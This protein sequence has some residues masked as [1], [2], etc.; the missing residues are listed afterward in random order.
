MTT[1][2]DTVSDPLSCRL[3][4]ARAKNQERVGVRGSVVKDGLLF[5]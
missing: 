3:G 2:T 5:A 1:L 4:A